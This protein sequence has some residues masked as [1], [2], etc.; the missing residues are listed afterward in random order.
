MEPKAPRIQV[1]DTRGNSLAVQFDYF[2]VSGEEWIETFKI[3]LKFLTFGD[4]TIQE[5]FNELEE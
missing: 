4:I 3:I 1:Q 2:D 5:L